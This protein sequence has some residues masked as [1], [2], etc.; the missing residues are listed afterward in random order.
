M[1]RSRYLIISFI[2][3]CLSMWAHCAAADRM[4]E[5]VVVDNDEAI[6][7]T[8]LDEIRERVKTQNIDNVQFVKLPELIRRH[9]SKNP[10]ACRLVIPIGTESTKSIVENRLD[11][12]MMSVALPWVNYQSL[13]EA[14][15]SGVAGR[16]SGMFSAIFLDQPISRRIA[17]L[18]EILPNADSVAVLLGPS[19]ID[20]RGR[21]QQ[22][23]EKL[24]YRANIGFFDGTRNIV[25]VLDDLLDNSDAL[26]GIGDPAVFNAENARNILLTAY[27]WRV[28]LLGLSPAYVRAG[29]LATV[30][31]SPSQFATQVVEIIEGAQD[32]EKPFQ[33]QPLYPEYFDVMVN[34]KVAEAIGLVIDTQD[35]L[36]AKIGGSDGMAP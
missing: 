25:D 5:I 4:R 29:S 36:R 20:T 21:L 33:V 12:P 8:L 1:K 16:D 17:L 2:T 10:Q 11:V 28:P 13:S 31:T 18:H 19:T 26:L 23:L 34:Y 6:Y 14:Y 27:R 30:F 3:A 22:T 32:C 24:G 9:R 7:K 15:N 35:R